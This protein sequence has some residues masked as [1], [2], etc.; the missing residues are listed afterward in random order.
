MVRTQDGFALA[1]LDL[2]L[3]GP[4]EFF[5]TRQSGLPDF[6]V[7]SLVRDRDLLE[8]AKAEARAFAEETDPAIT[9]AEK[10]A[11]WT[12]LRDTWQRRYGLMHAG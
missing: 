10:Q 4:G 6:R 2:E 5:G 3:R 1:E 7:A 11:V 9:K 12:A 8:N